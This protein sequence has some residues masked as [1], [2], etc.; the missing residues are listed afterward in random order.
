MSAENSAHRRDALIDRAWFYLLWQSGLR[1][2]EVE[3]LRLE[4]LDLESRKLTVRRGKGLIDRTVYLTGSVV[5]VLNSYLGVRGMGPTDHVFLYRNQPVCKGFISSRLKACG[6]QL[7]VKV[8]PHRLRHTCA[9][10]LLNAGCRIIS[11]Q[12]FLGH[13]RLNTTLVYARVHDQTVADDYFTAMSS[14]ERRLDLLEN[15]KEGPDPTILDVRYELLTLTD[16]LAVPQISTDLRL[17]IVARIRQV[18]K[19]VDR[20]KLA[21]LYEHPPPPG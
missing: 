11:I 12:R 9:T 2:G 13:K 3:D 17:G 14:V 18:L 19:V 1:L 6:S 15:Q 20:G 8:H 10:Q 4:D 21:V 5:H 7:G 16:Q